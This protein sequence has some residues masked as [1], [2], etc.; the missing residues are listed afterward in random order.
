MYKAL[1]ELSPDRAEFL[2]RLF[3]RPKPDGLPRDASVLQIWDAFLPVATSSQLFAQNHAAVLDHLTKTHGFA[4][5]DADRASITYVF[6]AFHE[7]GPTISYSGYNQRTGYDINTLTYAEITSF[8]DGSGVGRSFLGSEGNYQVIRN[9]H[10]KNLIVP[11]VADFAGPTGIRAIGRYLT[12]RNATV[13]AFY[14]SNVESYLFREALAPERFYANIASLPL[15]ATSTF[16]RPRGGPVRVPVGADYRAAAAKLTDSEL[17][18]ILPFLRAHAE[19][20][21][22]TYPEAL[23]CGT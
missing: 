1:F 18:P 15:D 19:G 20:R 3:S 21:I 16:I 4:L 8:A 23:N 9:L 10:L 2:S 12:E 6:K 17:C 14:T 13:T 11:V 7:L 5:S 22:R